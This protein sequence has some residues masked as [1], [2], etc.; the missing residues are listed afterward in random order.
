MYSSVNLDFYGIGE[1]A[2]LQNNP[3]RYNLQ[4]LGG[5]VQGKYRLSDSCFWAGIK[6]SFAS[7]QVTFDAPP[8][9]PGL[10]DFQHHSDVG[11]LAPSFTYDSRDNIFTAMRGT[12]VEVTAGLFSEAL[13]GSEEF[14]RVGLIAM[15]FI[16]L[17]P[18]LTLGIRGDAA[19]SFGDVPFYMR[20]FIS[21]RGYP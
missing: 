7:T 9:T 19:A 13:G 8:G 18:R 5:A 21:L 2:A 20:P 10:P 6:Y 14:Q 4:P 16:P 3:L 1:D 12:Y 17:H 15:Q 11:G